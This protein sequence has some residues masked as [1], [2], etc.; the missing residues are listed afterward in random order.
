LAPDALAAFGLYAVVTRFFDD[1]LLRITTDCTVRQVVLAASGLDTRAFRL[2]WPPGT[3]VFE[4]EQPHLLIYKDMLLAH[5]GVS[6]S[7]CVRHAVGV[8]LNRRWDYALRAAGFDASRPSV[9]LL[10]G[11]VYFLVEPAVLNLLAGITALA[12]PASWMGLDIVNTRMLVSPDTRHWNERM[13]AAGTPWMF[14]S[15]EPEALLQRFGWCAHSTEPGMEEAG[16]GRTPYGF[17]A[18]S[19]RLAPRSFLVTAIR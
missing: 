16:Y 19:D 13:T 10:E 14:S 3:E 7:S 15:D 1:F 6:S 5:V 17:S 12:A 2:A 11:F 9:W 4:L 8:D 18:T